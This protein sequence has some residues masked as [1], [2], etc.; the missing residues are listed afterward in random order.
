LVGKAYFR[1]IKAA[2]GCH[3]ANGFPLTFPYLFIQFFFEILPGQYPESE[4]FG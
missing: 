2:N 4:A 1:R 3:Q